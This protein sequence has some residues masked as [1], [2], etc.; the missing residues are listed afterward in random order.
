VASLIPLYNQQDPGTSLQPQPSKGLSS[1]GKSLIDRINQQRGENTA[2]WQ[3]ASISLNFRAGSYDGTSYSSTPSLVR[4]KTEF[5]C[6]IIDRRCLWVSGY[7]R[8]NR[9]DFELTA[10]NQNYSNVVDQRNKVLKY[11]GGKNQFA[12]Q[13]SEACDAAMTEGFVLIEPYIQ[14]N[15]LFDCNPRLKIWHACDFITDSYFR[16]ADLSDC[17]YIATSQIMP[18]E[19]AECT[20]P[21]A[22]REVFYGPSNQAQNPFYFQPFGK[23]FSSAPN[24]CHIIRLWNRKVLT[25]HYIVNMST[26]EMIPIKKPISPKEIEIVSREVGSPVRQKTVKE[27]GWALSVTANN[28]VIIDS[29]PNPLGFTECPMV[30]VFWRHN[31]T[32]LNVALRFPSLPAQLQDAQYLSDRRICMTHDLLEGRAQS[33]WLY[34]KGSIDDED[35]LWAGQNVSNIS[36]NAELGPP[37]PIAPT[38]IPP[39]TLQ[40]MEQTRDFGDQASPIGENLMGVNPQEGQSGVKTMLEQ[41]AGLVGLRPIFDCWDRALRL[42]GNLV[43]KIIVNNISREEAQ[44]I[45]GQEERLDP[46]FFNMHE[47]AASMA[48]TEG[49]YTDSQ[50]KTQFNQ[51][52]EFCQLT[53]TQLPPEAWA[54]IAPLQKSDEILGILAEQQ[55]QAAQQG[56]QQ[57][58][59]ELAIARA[60][61]NQTNADALDKVAMARERDARAQ[62]NIGLQDERESEVNKNDAI[63]AK[64]VVDSLVKLMEAKATF[65]PQVQQ[66][67]SQELLQM[68][69][70]I[71]QSNQMRSADADRRADDVSSIAE[72][73]QILDSFSPQEA[74]NENA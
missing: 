45:L 18:S 64:N 58:E 52:M 36:F 25:R 17:S 74:P 10:L 22:D 41:G 49:L 70:S 35:I 4:G 51:W 68:R 31:P 16:Q 44:M 40:L 69:A 61:I 62:S 54:K 33:G 63:Y 23:G 38:I 39:T 20:F 67:S 13:F 5:V 37:I 9:K 12:E 27:V 7:Q 65:S 43:D 55:K 72:D 21:W 71:Q 1:L 29:V 32:A 60:K 19:E 56:Q 48:V 14:P 28:K 15:A 2:R 34:P 53:G 73:K 46:K 57:Q 24:V 30:P 59:Y 6:N 26:G 66:E 47:G 3:A 42:V 11:F 8:Q 50:K